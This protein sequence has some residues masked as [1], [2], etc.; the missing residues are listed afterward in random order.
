MNLPFQDKRMKKRF[1]NA[2][3]QSILLPAIM[4]LHA[5]SKAADVQLI[6]LDP[7]HFHAALVQKMTYPQVDKTVHVYAPAGPDLDAHL[8]LVNGF[9]TR[10]NN[11]TDWTEKVYAGPDFLDKMA[12]ERAGNVVVI[13][14]NNLRKTEYIDRSIKAGFNVLADKPMAI[15][16]VEFKLLREDFAAAARGKLLL[17][18][19]MTERH[20]ITTILQRELSQAPEVFGKLQK[21]GLQSPAVEM[22]SIHHYFKEVAGKPLIRPAWALDVRQQG[23]GIPDVGTHLVDLVQW[24]CFPCKKLDW[25]KDVKVYDARRWAT[26]LTLA[27]FKKLTGQD[28]FPD[29]LKA[30]VGSDGSLQVFQNG[31]VNY[32]LL[33]VHARVTVKWDSEEGTAGDTH[34]SVMRGSKATLRIH[35]GAAENFVPTLYVEPVV[36]GTEFETALRAALA[37][38]AVEWP[39]LELKSKG[40]LWIVVIPEKYRTGHESHFA[41]VTK[42]YLDYLANRSMPAWEVPNMIAK[43]YTTTEAWRLSHAAK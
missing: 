36:G 28:A 30:D 37:K 16:P 18:D 9:N 15:T 31:E 26:S 5:P 39:G 11:P 24:E 29:Y 25:K 17:Y 40:N 1:L 33:G 34:Y 4:S 10:S 20:E 13:A 38:L 12:S 32:T 8:A 22:E 35:Q 43:Y 3:L 6:T 42:D 7:G 41:D 14:G 27:Q 19:I 23:E 2:L 21:G